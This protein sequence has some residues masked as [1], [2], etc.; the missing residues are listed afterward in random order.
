M[1]RLLCWVPL[2]ASFAA[3]AQPCEVPAAPKAAKVLAAESFPQVR[4]RLELR[5][6]LPGGTSDTVV[7]TKA[8]AGR[9]VLTLWTENNQGLEARMSLQA[10]TPQAE[11]HWMWSA[12]QGAVVTPAAPQSPVSPQ[13]RWWF[14][15]TWP[16]GTALVRVSYET[17]ATDA[18]AFSPARP[19]LRGHIS[20]PMDEWVPLWA[21]Q[22]EPPRTGGDT[23]WRSTHAAPLPRLDMRWRRE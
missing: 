13:V 1:K 11:L 3:V 22:A 15:P 2:W 16:G 14:C 6:S 19:A 12:S 9:S 10:P 18:A 17:P 20:V 8:G 7:S 5:D 21:P 4:L 23:V